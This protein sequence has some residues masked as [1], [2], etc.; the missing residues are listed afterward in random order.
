MLH[1]ATLPKVD[2]Y[3]KLH[4]LAAVLTFFV[5]VSHIGLGLSIALSGTPKSFGFAV[6]HSMSSNVDGVD[7]HSPHYEPQ[8]LSLFTDAPDTA[9]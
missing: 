4:I 9:Q 8:I 5:T 2:R 7:P 6:D 1:T 3:L